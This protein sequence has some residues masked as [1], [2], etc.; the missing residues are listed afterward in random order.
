[1]GLHLNIS[2]TK[3]GIPRAQPGIKNHDF[4]DLIEEVRCKKSGGDT[5]K[6]LCDFAFSDQIAGN[7]SIFRRLCR[8][9]M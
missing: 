1:M 5:I 3:L 9:K 2:Q 8:K 4:V 7:S 6:I